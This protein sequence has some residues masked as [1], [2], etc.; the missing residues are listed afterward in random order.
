MEGRGEGKE[1]RGGEGR[2]EL[3]GEKLTW[4]ANCMPGG[5][6]QAAQAMA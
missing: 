3:G 2:K 4:L 6:A 1:R 5:T